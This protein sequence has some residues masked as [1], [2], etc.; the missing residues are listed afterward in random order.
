MSYDNFKVE[1]PYNNMFKIKTK[2][3]DTKNHFDIH[4]DMDKVK[5][6]V[7]DV[8]IVPQFTSNTISLTLYI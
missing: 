3:Y 6:I 7:F 2:D 5:E 8:N 4:I 1:I